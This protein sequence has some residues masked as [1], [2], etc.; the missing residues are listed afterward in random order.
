MRRDFTI[1]DR[2]SRRFV[3][4][5][6]FGESPE[7]AMLVFS[8]MDAMLETNHDTRR[9]IRSMGS[10]SIVRGFN[11]ENGDVVDFQS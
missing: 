11:M 4:I 6:Y 1:C 8:D 10:D 2:Q 9:A 5:V 7:E 3:G